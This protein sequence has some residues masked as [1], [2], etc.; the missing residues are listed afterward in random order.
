MEPIYTLLIKNAVVCTASDVFPS[1]IA[2]TGHTITALAPNIDPSLAESV[3]D[4]QGAYVTPGGIDAHVHVDEPTKPF[5]NLSDTLE[6]ASRSAVAGGTTCVIAFVIQNP[7]YTG[8]DGTPRGGLVKVI[9]EFKEYVGDNIWCDWALHLIVSKLHSAELMESEIKDV[10]AEGVTSVKMY[11]TYPRLQ[12]RDKDLLTSLHT[13]RATGCTAMLH[14]ENGDVIAWMT[15]ALEEQGKTAPW[16]H[17]VSRP[18]LVEGEATNRAI[19]LAE[20]MDCPVLFVHVSAKEAFDRIRLAQGNSMPIFSETCMQYLVLDESSLKSTCHGD[21]GIEQMDSV[22]EDSFEASKYVC[23]PPLRS[24]ARDQESAWLALAN[25]TVTILSSDHAP[26]N[27]ESPLGKRAAFQNGHHGEF[28]NIPNGLPGV[29]TRVPLL[30]THGVLNRRIT[31]QKFVEVTSTNPAKLYGLYPQKGSILPGTSDADLVIW[32]PDDA[33][34]GPSKIRNE[35]LRHAT[36]HTPFEGFEIRNWPR[37]T[38]LKG[39]VVFKEEELQTEAGEGYGKFVKRGKS[40]MA[41]PVN[42]WTSEWRPNYMKP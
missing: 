39:R 11:M 24:H 6:T 13:L 31:L 7:E 15:D 41:F 28:R 16:F 18:G 5:G 35:N 40:N 2:I 29:E 1:D 25:G 4:A 34:T 27:F 8:A 22:G 38:I 21:H 12:M 32:Y 17:A 9:N 30:Y 37:Y 20:I 36:D 23:S 33:Y 26:T 14:A 3:M 42:K 19:V 10:M